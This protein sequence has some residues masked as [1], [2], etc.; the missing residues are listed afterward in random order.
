M[1]VS[2][3]ISLMYCLI[4]SSLKGRENCYC[5]EVLYGDVGLSGISDPCPFDV[6]HL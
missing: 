2:Y 6:F 3:V 1:I 5:A 4:Y